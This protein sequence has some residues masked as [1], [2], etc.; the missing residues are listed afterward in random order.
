M[1]ARGGVGGVD[2]AAKQRRG[3]MKAKGKSSLCR[4]GCAWRGGSGG[5]RVGVLVECSLGATAK[6]RH[7]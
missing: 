4:R 1:T 5:G 2:S 6:L 7:G 3:E